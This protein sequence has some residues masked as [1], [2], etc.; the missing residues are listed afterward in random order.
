ML[1]GVFCLLIM[2]V[3]GAP[4]V[5]SPPGSLSAPLVFGRDCAPDVI[6][7][8][9]AARVVPQTSY[10]SEAVPPQV[11]QAL[12]ASPAVATATHA[13]KVGRC[14]PLVERCWATAVFATW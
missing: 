9:S 7:P 14:K 3:L 11:P 2:F 4:L 13:E 5:K 1:F 6:L 12:S 8:S 10:Y